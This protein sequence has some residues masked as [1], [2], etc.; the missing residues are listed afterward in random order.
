MFR[1][2]HSRFPDEDRTFVVY[3]LTSEKKLSQ[4]R[5]SYDRR[6]MRLR[7]LMFWYSH[8]VP[9]VVYT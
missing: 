9:R 7:W 4:E 3:K 1:V 2:Q 5:V 6:G 8:L